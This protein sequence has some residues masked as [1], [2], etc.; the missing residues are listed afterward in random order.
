MLVRC[1]QSKEILTQYEGIESSNELETIYLGDPFLKFGISTIVQ[2]LHS[3][4]TED[5]VIRMEILIL[6]TT[7]WDLQS[8]SISEMVYILFVQ[9]GPEECQSA[10]LLEAVKNT[11]SDFVM[12]GLL[13]EGCLAAN[14]TE[15]T[16]AVLIAIFDV[17]RA[18]THKAHLVEFIHSKITLEWVDYYYSGSN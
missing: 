6:K 15:L 3:T 16:I 11:I 1:L 14:Y 2:L 18:N 4:K 12:F 5:E 13:L 8:P 7:N 17:Y 10:R 9:H